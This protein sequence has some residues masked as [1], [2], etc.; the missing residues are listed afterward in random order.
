MTKPTYEQL[1][2][3]LLES[4][5]NED[6]LR[7]QLDAN[8]PDHK[9]QELIDAIRDVA[10]AINAFNNNLISLIMQKF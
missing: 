4:R 7:R 1:E 2:R 6:A 8:H 10:T 5:D 9:H 3:K